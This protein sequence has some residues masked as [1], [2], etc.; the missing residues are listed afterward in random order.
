VDREREYWRAS[1][2]LVRRIGKH[3]GETESI[4]REA[5][6]RY[7]L[8][9][10]VALALAR[11]LEELAEEFPGKSRSWFA[12]AATRV[13]L[14]VRRARENCWLVK[15][16]PLLGDSYPVYAVSYHPEEREYYCT[17]S[18]HFGGI[19]RKME[20]CTH[21]AAVIV[22]KRLSRSLSEFT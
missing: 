19:K 20:I 6:E 2:F 13:L 4:A 8:S 16:S 1:L 15:G 22:Y 12:R 10:G 11:A 18:S 9:Y 3:I 5:S 17:C 21:V 14:G 7:G